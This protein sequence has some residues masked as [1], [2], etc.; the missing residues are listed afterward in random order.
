[1]QILFIY[2][3]YILFKITNDIVLQSRALYYGLWKKNNTCSKTTT[4]VLEQ[5]NAICLYI[6]VDIL[7]LILQHRHDNYFLN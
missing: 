1:M 3:I 2:I 7:L 5:Y 4:S 6:V